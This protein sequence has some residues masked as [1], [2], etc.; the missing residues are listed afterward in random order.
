MPLWIGLVISLT[1]F[2]I[3]PAILQLAMTKEAEGVGIPFTDIHINLTDQTITL[4]KE[5]EVVATL[6]FEGKLPAAGVIFLPSRLQ[7][8]PASAES[9]PQA[10][11]PVSPAP[12]TSG[13]QT[14]SD[15]APAAAAAKEKEKTITLSGKLKSKAQAGKPDRS[16][17]PTAYADFAAHVEGEE[18]A[19]DYVATFH[20]HTREI[21]LKLPKE[22]PITVTGYPHPSDSPKR[23]DTFSVVNLLEYP[24]KPPPKERQPSRKKP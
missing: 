23:K 17:K 22:A 12:A 1:D 2:L 24:G 14:L 6:I 20:R 8:L 3:F 13:S 4:K 7:T 18:N 19:H 16:G 9:V 15:V 11:E 10:I 5:A 21:A